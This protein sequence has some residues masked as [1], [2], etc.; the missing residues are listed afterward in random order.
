MNFSRNFLSYILIPLFILLVA[1]SYL[2][3]VV[4]N[5]YVVGYESDCD[6]ITNVCFVGCE[7]EECTKE[8][9]YK[10]MHKYAPNLY[11]Q[12]GEDITECEKADVCLQKDDVGCSVMYCDPK[13]DG[14]ECENISRESVSGE[15]IQIEQ[16]KND[17]FKNENT[18]GV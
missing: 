9:Y 1:S 15:P 12:C 14:N 10:K 5:D 4:L 17:L 6:P 13:V 8:Y 18:L 11:N 3:F 7:N 16:T 2:R